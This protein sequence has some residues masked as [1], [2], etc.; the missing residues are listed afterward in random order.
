M[1]LVH[2]VIKPGL[3]AVQLYLTRV[4]SGL[5]WRSGLLSGPL[6]PL[7]LLVL[8]TDLVATLITALALCLVTE[9]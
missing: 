8:T 6:A 9:W 7:K 5:R 2:M 4:G 3:C 1:G